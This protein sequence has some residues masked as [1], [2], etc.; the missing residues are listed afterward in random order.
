MARKVSINKDSTTIIKQKQRGLRGPIGESGDE[1]VDVKTK[2]ADYTAT[3]DDNTILA[4]ALTN[5]ITI[6]LPTA[7]D[8][9][10]KVFTI[11]CIDDTFTVDV[12]TLG[13]Q[14]IDGSSSNFVLYLHE[15][16]T[17]RC[18]GA[19]WWLI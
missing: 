12:E 8:N 18:D 2:I 14:E 15:A 5:T 7:I 4:K 19:N 17:L 10:G 13:I 1:Y 3:N 16:L 6:T 9:T 11:K